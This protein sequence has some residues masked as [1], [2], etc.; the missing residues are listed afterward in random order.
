MR[1]PDLLVRCW[2]V[3]EERCRNTGLDP[4]DCGCL[5]CMP[6]VH[7]FKFLGLEPECKS[8]DDIIDAIQGEID[9]FTQLKKEGYKV[10]EGDAEDYLEIIPPR[11]K[12]F[13]W[14]RCKT[15]GY[16]LELPKG[17]QQPTT[18]DNCHGVKTDE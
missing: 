9:Y 11:R 18:C 12:G 4:L 6:S 16:H 1:L 8:I 5:D 10:R 2:Q 13:Y 15:C 17:T 7:R 3:Y 14:G